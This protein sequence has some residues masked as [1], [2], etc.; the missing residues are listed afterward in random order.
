MLTSNLNTENH[1]FGIA[2]WNKEM[3]L[4]KEFNYTLTYAEPQRLWQ[5]KQTNKQKKTLD[6]IA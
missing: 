6:N 2:F 1:Y 3:L 4:G 5:K